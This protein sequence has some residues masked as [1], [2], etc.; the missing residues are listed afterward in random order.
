[1]LIKHDRSQPLL[2][3]ARLI[4]EGENAQLFQLWNGILVTSMCCNKMCCQKLWNKNQLSCC[5]RRMVLKNSWLKGRRGKIKG[6]N[7]SPIRRGSHLWSPVHSVCLTRIWGDGLLVLRDHCD[8]KNKSWQKKIARRYRNMKWRAAA[9]LQERSLI[10]NSYFK[11][12]VECLLKSKLGK[13]IGNQM[14]KQFKSAV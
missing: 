4:C 9:F 5:G 12:A 2:S 1:M 11:R 6:I 3:Q 13:K 10:C 7:S 14:E 8:G